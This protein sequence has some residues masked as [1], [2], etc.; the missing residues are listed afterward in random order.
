MVY[1]SFSSPYGE[2]NEKNA[3]P[4][5]IQNQLPSPPTTNDQTNREGEDNAVRALFEL[6]GN[7]GNRKTNEGAKLCDGISQKNDKRPHDPCDS[8]PLLPD[9]LWGE[10][11]DVLKT[12]YQ[13]V[14]NENDRCHIS[15]KIE[16]C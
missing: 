4:N 15:G 7:N 6:N 10:I 9:E 14:D 12:V 2:G 11:H 1:V 13:H 3:L 8:S 16:N 5:S